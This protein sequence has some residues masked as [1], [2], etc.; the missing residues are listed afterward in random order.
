MARVLEINGK[1]CQ[2]KGKAKV[3][4][5]KVHFENARKLRG[6]HFPEDSDFKETIKDGRKKLETSIAPVIY[7]L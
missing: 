1:A 3:S 2:A 7:A 4:E 5:E 6:I